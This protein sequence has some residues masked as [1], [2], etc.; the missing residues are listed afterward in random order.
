MLPEVVITAPT[1]PVAELDY[2]VPEREPT[3]QE[4]RGW[5]EKMAEKLF[6]VA[7]SR[8]VWGTIVSLGAGFALFR[9][10]AIDGPA[11]ASWT[12]DA[13]AL[14]VGAVGVEN[15]VRAWREKAAP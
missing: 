4:M 6:E 2:S 12:R 7:T 10:G 8:R 13:C 11:L 9:L 1:P 5:R 15:V 14:F 3:E